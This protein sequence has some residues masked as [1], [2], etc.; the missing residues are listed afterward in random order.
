MG[1]KDGGDKKYVNEACCERGRFE[2]GKQMM[3]ATHIELCSV[4]RTII[5][6]E[7]CVYG[8]VYGGSHLCD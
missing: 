2:N 4:W 3:W 6:G 5:L 7:G 1:I 8:S